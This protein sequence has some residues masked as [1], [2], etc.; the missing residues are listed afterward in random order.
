MFSEEKLDN[1]LLKK[2]K[3]SR[4][5][6][7][8]LLLLKLVNPSEQKIDDEDKVPTRVDH[9]EKREI[10]RSNLFSFNGLFQLIHADVRNPEFLR[11]SA[12]IPRYVLLAVDFHSSKVYVYL[13]IQENKFYKS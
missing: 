4:F 9:I 10:D 1:R 6:K 2:L 3:K 5:A 8:S 13:S 12:T 11:K 7:D